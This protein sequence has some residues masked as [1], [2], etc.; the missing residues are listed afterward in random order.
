MWNVVLIY[1]TIKTC[2]LRESGKVVEYE[3][4]GDTNAKN[5]CQEFG[6]KIGGIKKKQWKNQ[7]HWDH[8][9]V[10]IG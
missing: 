10:K 7:E 2:I 6:K 5:N 3:G 4:N 8:S 9:I 1:S